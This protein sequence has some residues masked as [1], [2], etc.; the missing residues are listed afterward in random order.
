MLRESPRG[1]KEESWKIPGDEV[2]N[3]NFNFNNFLSDD[4]RST[5][6]SKSSSSYL[7]AVMT[8]SVWSR[9]AEY[10]DLQQ[11]NCNVLHPLESSILQVFYNHF[12]LAHFE[13]VFM[14]IFAYEIQTLDLDLNLFGLVGTRKLTLPHNNTNHIW[15]CQNVC[16]FGLR[17]FLVPIHPFW[18]RQLILAGTFSPVLDFSW[19]WV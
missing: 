14:L 13:F 11:Q 8:S 2:E 5:I 6:S 10:Q 15:T 4:L 19:M 1:I 16:F 3:R 12:P 9:A 17:H 7:G 18:T